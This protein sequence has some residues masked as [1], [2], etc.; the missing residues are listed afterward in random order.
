MLFKQRILDLIARGE[1]TVA[2]RRWRR[3]TVKSGGRL[4][5]PVGELAI[6]EVEI[7][8]PEDITDTAARAAGFA[9]RAEALAALSGGDGQLY[10]IAFRLDREDPRKSLALSD[11]LDIEAVGLIRDAL[12]DLDRRGRGPDWTD[13]Y[14]HLLHLH[15]GLPAAELARMAGVEKAVLKRRMR[16]L[17]ELGLTESL[18][19]G[20]R[21][22]PRGRRVLYGPTLPGMDAP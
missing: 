6:G 9:D 14:L 7:V 2:F 21:L 19:V 18:E 8:A 16:L 15:A 17:K 1:V 12:C 4:R 11:D 3:P 13:S 5:T 10:R 22:S 20:Y